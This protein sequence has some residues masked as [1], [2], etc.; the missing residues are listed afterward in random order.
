[1]LQEDW[2]LARKYSK[3]G[4]LVL[5]RAPS[6]APWVPSVALQ[7]VCCWFCLLRLAPARGCLA[8]LSV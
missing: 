1:R 6:A 4:V 8:R 7:Q 2:S 5:L 3:I